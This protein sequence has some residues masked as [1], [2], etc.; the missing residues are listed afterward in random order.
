MAILRNFLN[1]LVGR[2]LHLFPVFHLGRHISSMMA[3]WHVDAPRWFVYKLQKLYGH[4]IGKFGVL[5]TLWVVV[6]VAAVSGFLSLIISYRSSIRKRVQ[7]VEQRLALGIVYRDTRSSTPRKPP[8]KVIRALELHPSFLNTTDNVMSLG[9]YLSSLRINPLELKNGDDNNNSSLP[10]FVERELEATIASILL[11][12][13]GPRLGGALLPM[14]GISK[15][16]SWIANVSARI[17]TFV[18]S[19]LLVEASHQWDP[20]EDRG[21]FPFSIS[22]IVSFVN[23]N[24]KFRSNPPTDVSTSTTKTNLQGSPTENH[25][26]SPLKWMSRGE[27]GY[28]PSFVSDEEVAAKTSV[29]QNIGD[30]TYKPA[31]QTELL[32]PNPFIMQDHFQAAIHGLEDRIRAQTHV[33][34]VNGGANA[35]SVTT[36]MEYEPNDRSL[37]APILINE[38]VLPGLHIG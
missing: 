16:D 31:M 29:S 21:V 36:T 27:I 17:A 34:A 12:N 3:M 14:L 1:F 9:Q 20:T 4:A 19:Y 23:L 13:F 26:P 8:E 5:G 15:I 28:S 25:N 32:L 30:D 7:Q 22:E 18:A 10:R 38:R 6:I 35:E 24:Q 2:D 37:P 11:Q 33:T